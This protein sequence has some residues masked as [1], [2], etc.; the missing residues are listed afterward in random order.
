MVQKAWI[1][2]AM[3]S[4]DLDGTNARMMNEVH[5]IHA[6]FVQSGEVGG[7]NAHTAMVNLVA[8]VGVYAAMTS[9]VELACHYCGCKAQCRS[10]LGT[11]R[12]LNGL[13][14]K[15][16]SDDQR[17]AEMRWLRQQVEMLSQENVRLAAAVGRLEGE[18]CA[19]T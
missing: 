1:P 9:I 8:A 2:G 3:A 15:Q 17:Q 12:D 6:D 7:F 5:G 10:C 16:V 4:I 18:G 19:N 14:D 11:S 13:L